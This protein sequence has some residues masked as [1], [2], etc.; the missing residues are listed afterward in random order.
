[1]W[2][3]RRESTTIRKKKEVLTWTSERP[4]QVVSFSSSLVLER[5]KERERHAVT[6]THTHASARLRAKLQTHIHPY[7][8][9]I[10]CMTDYGHITFLFHSFP[11]NNNYS[12]LYFRGKNTYSFVY[13]VNFPVTFRNE[14]TP[15][16]SQQAPN[17]FSRPTKYAT[18]W[19]VSEKEY[20]KSDDV[21]SSP[22]KPLGGLLGSG[23]VFGL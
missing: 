17:T 5:E 4:M 18:S 14:S 1:M 22:S 13:V 11:G 20:S 9:R 23:G 2:E 10:T 8:P 19:S 15:N 16:V 3:K 6:H 7:V 21:S 12:I